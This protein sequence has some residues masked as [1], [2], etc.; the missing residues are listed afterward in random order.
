MQIK[1]SLRV[2]VAGAAML[3]L[4]ATTTSTWAAG[5][6]EV[7]GFGSNP[8]ALRMFKFVPDGLPSNPPLVVALH[9]CSQGASDYDD[10]TGWTKF[11]ENSHFV[12]LLP[13]QQFSNNILRC[14]N[15]FERADTERDQGEALSIKQ[16]IDKIKADHTI[17]ATRIYVTG[18]SAGGG[19]TTVMLATYPEL[20]AG[21]AII[22]GL[23]YRCASGSSEA[24]S[25][26]K[27]G[28]N[29]TPSQWGKLVRDAS[30]HT[31][32]WPKVSI[33]QGSA[34]TTVVPM[35]AT[36]LVDQ[37]TNVHAIDQASDGQ[38]L[39]NGHAHRVF[40]DANGTV[41]VETFMITGMGHGTPIAP[42]SGEDQCGTPGRPF[43][44]DVGVC[45]S[46]HI[47]Q[48]WGL[49]DQVPIQPANLRGELLERITT[50]QK[51][52]GELHSIVD[53]RLPQ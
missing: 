26:M 16:M 49:L 25:C 14:F 42:G 36:E 12:L 34:D 5:L 21:G 13:D 27:P 17:N 8:G 9:G 52:L 44:L 10:E 29:L 20:F 38:D 18:L 30:S 2:T 50:I 4:G 19:M 15:W 6:T 48:F 1:S 41:L 3:L 31:G 7:T 43:I 37:W 11:A 45:S 46:F 23:P 28:K 33:W 47:A 32:S 35:N 39:V 53:Q 24:F 51:G 22:A 40:K